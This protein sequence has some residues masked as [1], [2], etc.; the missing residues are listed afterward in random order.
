MRAENFVVDD[1][2]DRKA[3]EA[4]RERLPELRGVSSLACARNTSSGFTSNVPS[5]I[6]GGKQPGRLKSNNANSIGKGL[7]FGAFRR[8]T[9][10]CLQ[11]WNR[12]RG[13]G[14]STIQ[15]VGDT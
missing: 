10:H 13:I 14:G 12:P 3:V 9:R 4:I 7:T 1:R 6:S 11:K 15:T 5:L 2:R 8:I